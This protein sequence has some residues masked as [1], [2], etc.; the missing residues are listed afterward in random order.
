LGDYFTVN[1]MQ[2]IVEYY[3]SQLIACRMM[4]SQSSWRRQ[5][6]S[7]S[8]LTVYT[9]LNDPFYQIVFLYLLVDMHALMLKILDLVFSLLFQ[10]WDDRITFMVFDS[11]NRLIVCMLNSTGSKFCDKRH[12]GMW[13]IHMIIQI[14][15]ICKCQDITICWLLN[16]LI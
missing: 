14:F 8:A 12:T 6:G 5:M 9:M 16:V 10:C 11:L 13:N 2:V 15:R 4:S 1:W 7:S 3:C